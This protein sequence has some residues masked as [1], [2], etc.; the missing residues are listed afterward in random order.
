MA[1]NPHYMCKDVTKGTLRRKM[2]I[3]FCISCSRGHSTGHFDTKIRCLAQFLKVIAN[4]VIQ[5]MH[6]EKK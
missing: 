1:S 4:T 6:C 5:R 3:E 2:K